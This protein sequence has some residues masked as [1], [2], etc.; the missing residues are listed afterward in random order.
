MISQY[1]RDSVALNAPIRAEQESLTRCKDLTRRHRLLVHGV[2]QCN[3][4]KYRDGIRNL[5]EADRILH[6]PDL[7]LNIGLCYIKDRN[8]ADAARACEQFQFKQ[9]VPTRTEEQNQSLADCEQGVALLR[10]FNRSLDVF[11]QRAYND[12]QRV[13]HSVHKTAL[14]EEIRSQSLLRVGYSQARLGLFREAQESCLAYERTRALVT[15][16]TE[17]ARP[18]DGADADPAQKGSATADEASQLLSDC[19]ALVQ[20][21][22]VQSP[23]LVLAPP[24]ETP[25]AWYK[26]WWVWAVAGAAVGAVAVGLGV[27]LSKPTPAP[28]QN[29]C[30]GCV[31]ANGPLT[32]EATCD[33]SNTLQ[34]TGGTAGGLGNEL[35]PAACGLRWGTW[36]LPTA[37]RQWRGTYANLRSVAT[38]P[39]LG[40][41][42]ADWIYLGPGDT[43]GTAQIC[44]TRRRCSQRHIPVARR[45]TR[46]QQRQPSVGNAEP[47]VGKRQSC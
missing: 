11:Q 31:N 21:N 19:K 23:L 47:H 16:R 33:E 40:H 2:Q 1:E 14:D 26:R 44:S 25:K 20:R 29:Q 24:K 22:L 4:D 41:P 43:A 10:D 42:D 3:S 5:A 17:T 15:P 37:A 35:M 18:R 46:P 13:C 6:A 27:G 9:E 36:K 32:T 7:L 8:L 45:R 39:G 34:F 28:D 12:A 38:V 30:V